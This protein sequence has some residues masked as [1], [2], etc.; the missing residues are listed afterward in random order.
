MD[1]LTIYFI[2]TSIL[3]VPSSNHQLF[4]FHS[5]IRLG[6]EIHLALFYSFQKETAAHLPAYNNLTSII[7]LLSGVRKSTTY[8]ASKTITHT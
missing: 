6:G 2:Q 4:K 5:L 3:I 8:L 7:L 1:T